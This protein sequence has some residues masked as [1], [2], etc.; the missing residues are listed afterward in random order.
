MTMKVSLWVSPVVSVMVL[1]GS[2]G[3]ATVTGDWVTGGRVE[4]S[5]S[6]RISADDVKGWMTL[7]QAA[8]GLGLPVAAVIELIDPQ[9]A[10]G[11]SATT[12]FREVEPL[13]PGF[14]LTTFRALLRARLASPAAPSPAAEPSR[15]RR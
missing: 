9:G 8:D 14:E 3:V 10:A 5:Q 4:V 15:S 1:F 13:V 11:L 7:Q 6:S 12:L 2:V